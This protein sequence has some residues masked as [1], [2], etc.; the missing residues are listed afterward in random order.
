[1]TVIFPEEREAKRIA[2]LDTVESL[3]DVFID[4][5]DEAEQTGTLPS[6]TVDAIDAA[7]LFSYKAARE[8]GGAEA[9]ALTQLDVIEAASRIDP[10]AGWCIMICSGSQSGMSA[11]LSEESLKEICVNGKLPRVAGAAAP[12]GQAKVLEDGYCVSGRWQFASGIRHSNYLAF[13]AMT[14]GDIE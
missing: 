4:G 13:G 1:M 5:A 12:S 10:A 14:V 2:L 7:G 6:A 3:R 11:Y 9:D 8:F